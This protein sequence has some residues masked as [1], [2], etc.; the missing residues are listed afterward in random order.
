MSGCQYC[1]EGNVPTEVVGLWIH[2]FN[3]RWHSCAPSINVAFEARETPLAP[4]HASSFTSA[5]QAALLSK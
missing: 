1:V 3:D 4:A 5:P 2:Q